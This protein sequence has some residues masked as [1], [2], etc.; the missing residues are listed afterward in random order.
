MVLW[1]TLQ[2]RRSRLLGVIAHEGG[3][4]A[5][6]NNDL[7]QIKSLEGEL[8]LSHKKKDYGLTVSTKELVYQKPHMNYI[9]KLEHI[10]SMIPYETKG[11][12]VQ[13][14]A[15]RHASN[16]ITMMGIGE[17]HYRIRTLGA[18]VHSRSGL[19]E[20]GPTEFILPVRP[21]LLHYIALYGQM[22]SIS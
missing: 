10:V 7:M 18:T 14:V 11:R 1:Y 2:N 22:N 12:P 4:T 6:R 21:E 8:K 19:F 9:I 13:F 3:S 17:D 20:L 15:R 5:L 16:E